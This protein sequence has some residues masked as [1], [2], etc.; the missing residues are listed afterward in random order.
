MG[1]IRKRN[2]AQV[3]K[4]FIHFIQRGYFPYL[5]LVEEHAKLFDTD[6]QIRLI[7]LVRD[8]PPK[9]AKHSP[10]LDR[11]VEETKSEE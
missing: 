3:F 4:E 5:I 8:V 6:P 1:E 9:W 7:K 2:L 10:L 11:G